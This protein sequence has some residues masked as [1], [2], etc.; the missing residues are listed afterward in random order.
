LYQIDKKFP[1]IDF[2]WTQELV[3]LLLMNS[4]YNTMEVLKNLNEEKIKAL[5]IGKVYLIII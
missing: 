3:L 1:I 4:N 2:K 5:I